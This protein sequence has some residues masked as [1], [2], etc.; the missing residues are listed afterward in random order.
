MQP[1]KGV[2]KVGN[3]TVEVVD[4]DAYCDAMHIAHRVVTDQA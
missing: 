1:E 3:L 4:G 2:A